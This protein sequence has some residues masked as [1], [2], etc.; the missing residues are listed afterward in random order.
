MNNFNREF[1]KKIKLF[2]TE[3]QDSNEICEEKYSFLKYVFSNLESMDPDNLEICSEE[4]VSLNCNLDAYYY[5]EDSKTYNLY[6]A[7]YND[8]IED[9]V[10]LSP[11]ETEKEYN[12]II[13]FVTRV[14]R[15]KYIDL[16]PASFTYEIADSIS[17]SIQNDAEL[18]VNIITNYAIPKECKKDNVE[19]IDNTNVSFRTYDFDDLENKFKQLGNESVELDLTEKFGCGVNALRLSSNPDFDVYCFSM[20]GAWLATLYKEDSIRLLEPNVRSYLKRTAKVN[21]G[22]L[23]T[24]KTSPE[25]FISFNN[26]ISA[27]ASNVT[28]DRNNSILSL[29]KITKIENFQIVNGGQTT[30]TLYE[31][32]K[33][34]LRSN[35]DAVDVI[36]KLTVVKNVA[37]SESLIRNISVYSNTQTGIKKSDPPSN[38]PYYVEIKKLSQ[39]C[40]SSKA[41]MNYICYFERTNGEYSTECRRNNNTKKFKN[42]NP[43]NMKFTK[44][45]LAVAIDC[46]EQLPY[47]VCQGR[48]KNFAF[49][50]EMVKNQMSSPDETYFKKAYATIILFRKFDS[51]A[52]KLKLSVTS[53]VVSYTL[54][55]VS[56]IYDKHIDLNEIWELKDLTSELTNLAYD[57]L[58]KVHRA[59]IDTPEQHPEPRMWARKEACWD[60]VKQISTN[61][62]T[63]KYFEKT[64]F[65]QKNDALLF[66]N[67][68]NNFSNSLIWS[69]LLLWNDKYK[70]L[71]KKQL[72]M[73]KYMRN[74]M[75]YS[76][77]KL[78]KKQSDFAKDIFLFAV[79]NGFSY[80]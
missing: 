46:W 31:C 64:E 51:I 22:I 75:D 38:M 56:L 70:A 27:V 58:P 11:Q 42:A 15:K 45:E 53:N 7:I 65:F 28:I 48:E 68:E 62:F 17:K 9:S 59:I 76:S 21:A 47:T 6:I 13:N 30:A 49:F 52:K 79:K 44:I 80:K 57:L 73:A 18:V 12:K 24:V 40:I 33:D 32:Y 60:R 8:E 55:L 72:S 50:N 63:N 69:K 23:E 1:I 74:A 29:S 10:F 67:D 14:I 36:V 78:T 77:A 19:T 16:D 66:I 71:N 5:D 25:E 37:N 41:G 2:H 35:L 34:N 39:S 3:Q 20:K 26:G 4:F 54:S 61:Q 43:S